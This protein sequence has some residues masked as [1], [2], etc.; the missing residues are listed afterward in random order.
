MS[1][2]AAAPRRPREYETIYIMRPDVSREGAAKVAQRVQEVL[3]R[4]GAKLTLVETWGRRELAYKVKK[5][6]YGIY[7]YVKFIATGTTVSELERN[8]RLLDEVMKFQSILLGEVEGEV[9]V[10]EE[11]VAFEPVEGVPMEEDAAQSLARELGLLDPEP[12]SRGH[13][14]SSDADAGDAGDMDEDDDA[15]EDE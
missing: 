8:F 11:S 10:S 6:R 5:H 1:S 14:R 7:V 15:Q 9:E 13:S 4:E 12:G 2:V 3:Q